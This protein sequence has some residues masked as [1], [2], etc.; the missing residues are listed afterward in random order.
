LG[1][2]FEAKL[3]PVEKWNPDFSGDID[4][5][6]HANG[7]WYFEGNPIA[8]LELVKLFSSILIF[9]DDEYYLVTPIEKWRIQVDGF[10]FVAS[11]P[12]SCVVGGVESIV[13]KTNTDE[14]LL[15]SS[16]HPIELYGE[17]EE[18]VPV[19]TVRRNLLALVSRPAYY[20][21]VELASAK[22]IDGEEHLGVLSQGAFY[23][24][25]VV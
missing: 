2:D 15:V 14:A 22:I 3:P 17:G 24:L 25:G 12:E 1:A 4:I 21:L 8:R 7:V 11:S 5:H 18:R 23:S 6:I 10:P 20:Q 9:E 19:I 16:D 13:L